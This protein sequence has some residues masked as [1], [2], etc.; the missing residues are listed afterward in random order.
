MLSR[1][2]GQKRVPIP[3]AMM[4]TARF[5]RAEP[6]IIVKPSPKPNAFL[7]PESFK[8]R[9]LLAQGVLSILFATT[10]SLPFQVGL[11]SF[12]GTLSR[13]DEQN[14]RLQKPLCQDKPID[15]IGI[16]ELP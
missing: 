14:D 6:L 4:M 13:I 3:P 2:A 5:S 12:R 9:A 7:S 16:S 1:L 11:C 10:S 8:D 15:V